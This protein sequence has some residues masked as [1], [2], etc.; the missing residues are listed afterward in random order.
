LNQ[1]IPQVIPHTVTSAMAGRFLVLVSLLVAVVAGSVTQAHESSLMRSE[2]S[3]QSE[4]SSDVRTVDI[5]ADSHILVSKEPK[6]KLKIALM[7]IAKSNKWNFKESVLGLGSELAVTARVRK[8]IGRWI[9][10]Y[11]VQTFVDIP[12]GDANWQAHIPGLEH[13]KYKGY[14]IA[15]IPIQR[16]RQNNSKHSWMSFQ[17]MDLTREIPVKGDIIMVRDVLQHL[18][19]KK[20]WQMLLNAQKKRGAIHCCFNLQ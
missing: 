9:R 16:A 4:V 14:D 3:R 5:E 6:T 11:K 18:P 1:P 19:L 12:C 8:C 13:V 2:Q 7:D 20:G 17:Q 10:K 15:D